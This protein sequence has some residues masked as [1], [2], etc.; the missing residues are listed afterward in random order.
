MGVSN[1]QS[2]P[3]IP[4]QLMFQINLLALV[5]SRILKV[6][7]LGVLFLLL[8]LESHNN[9]SNSHGQTMDRVCK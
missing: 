1:V 6:I 4:T 9:V 2:R 5:Q 7:Q 8:S 3:S